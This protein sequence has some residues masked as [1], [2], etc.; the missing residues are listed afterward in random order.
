MVA[1]LLV[2]PLHKLPLSG[3]ESI[4]NLPR[5]LSASNSKVTVCCL[6][7][8]GNS[9]HG[10]QNLVHCCSGLIDS[11]TPQ[12]V[13]VP[14]DTTVLFDNVEHLVMPYKRR[15]ALIPLI[16]ISSVVGC[17]PNAGGVRPTFPWDRQVPSAT[18]PWAQPGVGLSQMAVVGFEPTTCGL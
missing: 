4:A 1:P 13:L 2:P 7:P 6:P 11:S 14:D 9:G 3:P 12:F 17:A 15:F 10:E 8:P 16:F 18:N 5:N